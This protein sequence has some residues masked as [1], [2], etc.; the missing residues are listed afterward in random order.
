MDK[1][2]YMDACR[3]R[4]PVRWHKLLLEFNLPQSCD[5]LRAAGGLDTREMCAH[6]YSNSFFIVVL[7]R[8]DV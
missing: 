5:S 8:L 3:R 2:L 1:Q 6:E 7:N 4:V